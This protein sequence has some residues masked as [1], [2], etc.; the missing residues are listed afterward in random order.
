MHLGNFSIVER[1]LRYKVSPSLRNTNPRALG[2]M[3]QIKMS[4][5]RFLGT[6]LKLGSY[7]I[8]ANEYRCKNA[9][10]VYILPYFQLWL[11]V[12][13]MVA[14]LDTMAVFGRDR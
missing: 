7:F 11:E 13:L 6:M 4:L 9:L 3:W 14:T 1:R 10:D 2:C 5:V 8:G 12:C